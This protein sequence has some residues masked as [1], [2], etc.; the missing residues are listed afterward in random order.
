MKNILMTHNNTSQYKE[1]NN[2]RTL[3][4]TNQYKEFNNDN[5]TSMTTIVVV[6]DTG[7]YR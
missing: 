2:N 7:G 6:V 5:G 4:N 1:F 3:N